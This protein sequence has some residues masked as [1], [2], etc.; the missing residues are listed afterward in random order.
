MGQES[1]FLGDIILDKKY[2]KMVGLKAEKINEDIAK[3]NKINKRVLTKEKESA[4]L[5][6]EFLIALSFYEC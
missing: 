2:A 3:Q 6:L 4:I 5:Y 1:F